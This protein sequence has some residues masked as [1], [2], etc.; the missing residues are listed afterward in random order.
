MRESEA[1]DLASACQFHRRR[2]GF[3]GRAG[4]DYIVD[5][6]IIAGKGRAGERIRAIRAPFGE[7]KA[8]LFRSRLGPSERPFDAYGKRVGER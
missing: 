8:G 6:D 1:D 4:S 2:G 7:L 3:H 5:K